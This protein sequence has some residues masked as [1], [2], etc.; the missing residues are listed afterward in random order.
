MS[1]FFSLESP[2]YK[3]MSRLWDMLKL[4]IL[5]L[6]CSGLAAKFVLEYFLLYFGLAQFRILSFLPLAFLGAATTAVYVVTIR[7]VDEQEGYIARSFFKAY[8]ENFKRGCIL[9]IIQMVAVYAVYIDFQFYRNADKNNTLFL[10]V[11]VIAAV[12]TFM[13]TVYAFPL[14]SRY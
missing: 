2:F 12:L 7:M 1:G 4:N 6:L 10:I 5:W 14:L 3:F 8:K 9:G 11:G 13:H